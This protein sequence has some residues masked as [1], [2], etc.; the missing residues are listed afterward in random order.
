MPNVA[1]DDFGTAYIVWNGNEPGSSQLHFCSLPRGARACQNKGTL[2]SPGG[3]TLS[4][5]YVFVE[6]ASRRGF[7]NSVVAKLRVVAYRYLTPIGNYDFL[8]T[9]TNSGANFDAPVAAGT[10]RLTGDAAWGP[11]DG[12]SVVTSTTAQSTY[13]RIP[14]TGTTTATTILGADD[15]YGSAVGLL[16]PKRPLAVFAGTNGLAFSSYQGV[17]DYNSA[18]SWSR[19]PQLLPFT[20]IRDG[21]PHLAGGPSGLWLASAGGRGAV[22]LMRY[23]D[24]QN[25]FAT[26]ATPYFGVDLGSGANA[27][28]AALAQDPTGR[29]Y[30][31][32]PTT[33]GLIVI[34]GGPLRSQPPG[35]KR[36][37]GQPYG[38]IGQLGDQRI[39]TADAAGV[40]DTRIAVGP[41]HTAVVAWSTNTGGGNQEIHLTA[42]DGRPPYEVKANPRVAYNGSQLDLTL[43]CPARIRC[44]GTVTI[45]ATISKSS[46]VRT[47][48]LGRAT[49]AIASGRTARVRPPIGS[50]ARAILATKNV[51]SV[52]ATIVSRAGT[53]A[54]STEQQVL[55]VVRRR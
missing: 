27:N 28:F 21:Y 3:D 25:G 11:G 34:I 8:W 50:Q 30:V 20:S 17:G 38:A 37:Y 40:A 15:S 49:F 41:D 31:A 42:I 9:S 10:V 19:P 13:Q 47:V 45:R 7:N 16:T 52:T 5:P 39:E 48:T 14:L 22:N 36:D 43:R 51:K 55:T 23:E 54:P 53:S 46:G 6:S 33:S 2:P 18:A 26:L 35:K 44:K 29:L 24:S 32:G 1:V 12:I 4:R